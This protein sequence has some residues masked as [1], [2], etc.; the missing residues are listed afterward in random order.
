MST[1]DVIKHF[2]AVFVL[3]SHF[4]KER[5]L[6]GGDK[7]PLE[8]KNLETVLRVYGNR[9]ALCIAYPATVA[10]R[11]ATPWTYEGNQGEK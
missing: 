3:E 6:L 9:A 1:L 8:A 2:G 10:W 4:K 5:S 11:A 7:L